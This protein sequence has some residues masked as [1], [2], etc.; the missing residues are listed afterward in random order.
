MSGKFAAECGRAPARDVR[1]GSSRPRTVA[2]ALVATGLLAGCGLG[3]KHTSQNPFR[4]S[5][6]VSVP[7]RSSTRPRGSVVLTSDDFNGPALATSTWTFVNPARDAK[8]SMDGTQ[9]VIEVPRGTDTATHD[10][11]ANGDH[12]PR[13]MQTVPNGDFSFDTK[14]DSQ[15]DEQFQEQGVV[16]EQD[17]THYLYAAI[18]QSFSKTSI[19][20]SVVSDLGAQ[21]ESSTEIY[22]KPSIVLRVARAGDQWVV[23]Y[24]YDAFHWTPADPFVDALVVKQVG[25]F[26]GNTGNKAPAFTAKIDSFLNTPASSTPP[27]VHVWYG[28][29]Q[30]FGAHGRPQRWVNILGDVADPAGMSKLTYTVDDGKSQ[31][32]SMGENPFRLVEPGEFNA[33]ID[34]DSLHTGANRVA[35][36]ATDAGG[37]RS[38]TVVTVNK[39]AD[40]TWPVP[41][42]A[43]WSPPGG[44]VNA[45]AQVA[46]GHWVIQPGGTIHN[47]DF[48]FDRLVTIGDERAWKEYEATAQVT[49]NAM[50]PDGSSVGLITGF[51]GATGDLHGFPTPDQPRIGHPF[52]AAFL[53]ANQRGTAPRAEIYANTDTEPEQ[54][55]AVD[56]TGFKMTPRTAYTF[57]ISVTD[58][59]SAGSLFRFK[60]WKTGAAEPSGWMLQTDGD[61]A[62][63]ARP[64]RA[65]GGR[66][67]RHRDGHS[68]DVSVHGPAPLSEAPGTAR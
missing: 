28:A 24:S 8:Q 66:R 21:T 40:R 58:V 54:A 36:T 65:P 46:D 56:T 27:V 67:L 60:A 52:P 59:N 64:R 41:Y 9:A 30:T 20:V 53:Y 29:N 15:V 25:V 49:I 62:R 38:T 5:S 1:T 6:S 7:A 42:V 13:L 12:A 45:V 32:L 34:F 47:L 68:A 50:D 10:P 4:S 19:V 3:A 39:V 14:F 48:G 37:R 57:K 61:L 18:E 35:L 2:L 44:D 17:A 55:L 43:Q 31:P 63:V 22:N 11:D 26:A 51:Q 16:V 33:E 23:S